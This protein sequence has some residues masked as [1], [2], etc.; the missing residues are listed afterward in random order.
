[1]EVH[2]HPHVEKKRFKE[3]FLEFLM[4]FLAV[5]LG[6]FAETLRER[7]EAHDREK[8]YLFSMLQDLRQ[9]SSNIETVMRQ[10]TLILKGL[11][12]LAGCMSA[13]VT[14]RNVDSVYAYEIKYRYDAPHVE[15]AER[16]LSQLKNNGGL[17]LI[18][19]QT[20]SDGLSEYDQGIR[21][22]ASS[23]DYVTHYYQAMEESEKTLFDFGPTKP[24]WDALLKT[25]SSKISISEML[26]YI[27]GKTHMKTNDYNI[28]TRYIDEIIYDQVALGAYLNGDLADQLQ[29]AR[30]L[31]SL[32]KKYYHFD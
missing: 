21:A 1:M 13:P 20:I 23:N 6:F 9:D 30:S 25:G 16:T 2:H 3:Y 15:F 5:T 8:E 31:I 4:I 11:D 32:I 27:K 7:M 29:R 22:C 14:P 10:G 24:L 26:N 18:K 28:Y 17:R 12:T 19:N